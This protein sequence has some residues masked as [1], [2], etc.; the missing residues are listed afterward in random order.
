MLVIFFLSLVGTGFAGLKGYCSL[1]KGTIEILKRPPAELKVNLGDR[2]SILCA[3]HGHG[4]SDPYVYWIKGLGPG[5]EEKG[6]NMGPVAVGKSTLYIE[7]VTEDDIDTY[8]C[9]VKDCCSSKQENMD[10]DIHVSDETCE[11]VY[12]LGA[13]LYGA[14]WEFKN[15]TA[16]VQ[17]CK[18]KG[19]RIAF[20]QNPAENAKL[21]QDIQA[22]FST[23]P[24]ARKYAHE[25][26]VWI[27]G[28]DTAVEGV[29]RE[30]RSGELVN[31]FNWEYSQ[32]D[33]WTKGDKHLA[34][35]DC[36][37]IRRTNG[38]WDDSFVHH[39]RPYVCECPDK[40]LKMKN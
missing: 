39:E 9:V 10:V 16:A 6:K 32:P 17:S 1:Y 13:V 4:M 38:K 22:S 21:L 36:V 23:H 37:G 24:N 11:D 40:E 14:T 31:W 18:E 15:W 33:N 30:I 26:W 20:P 35:Q 12:G 2:V 28:H 27:G 34:G 7:K 29:W 25:N 19:M 5:Y 8:R 3:A